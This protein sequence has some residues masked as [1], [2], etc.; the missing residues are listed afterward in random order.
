LVWHC[1]KCGL[2]GGARKRKEENITPFNRARS[3]CQR[4]CRLLPPP[5]PNGNF[6]AETQTQHWQAFQDKTWHFGILANV[7]YICKVLLTYLL[8]LCCVLYAVPS[9]PTFP[10][11][12]F[13]LKPLFLHLPRRDC[14]LGQ[15]SPSRIVSQLSLQISRHVTRLNRSNPSLV[16]S[17][18]HSVL[19]C[20]ESTGNC[21]LGHL[22]FC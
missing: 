15:A 9:L 10:P 4:H 5:S 7:F 17:H 22:G 6:V 18:P 13:C 21:V 3:F 2:K 16:I 1:I 11:P 20:T 14:I 19:H 12:S 8:H